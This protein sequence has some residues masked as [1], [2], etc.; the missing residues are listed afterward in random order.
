MSIARLVHR[1]LTFSTRSTRDIS[2]PTLRPASLCTC[3]RGPDPSTLKST[4]S[5]HCEAG[6]QYRRSAGC[7]VATASSCWL[8][9][10]GDGV[11]E[12][13]DLLACRANDQTGPIGDL[14]RVDRRN[15]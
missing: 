3:R 4:A 10:R 8:P 13:G 11:Y 6:A 1:T 7:G 9:K 5:Q 12:W 2:R 14:P 15:G